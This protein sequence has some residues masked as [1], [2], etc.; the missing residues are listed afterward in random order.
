MSDL[1][2]C[3][4]CD[5]GPYDLDVVRAEYDYSSEHYAERCPS[6]Q[7]GHALAWADERS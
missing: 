3:L 2:I 6:C 4:N 7:Q 1:V 5:S